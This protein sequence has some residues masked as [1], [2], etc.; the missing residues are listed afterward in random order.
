MK[1]K[2]NSKAAAPTP[3]KNSKKQLEPETEDDEESSEDKAEEEEKMVQLPVEKAD[4]AKFKKD[5]H[6]KVW[7]FNFWKKV[8]L[9]SYLNFKIRRPLPCVQMSSVCT[10]VV[11]L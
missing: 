7:N 8:V 3:T 1:S 5:P 9:F 11:L 6:F 2:A 4:K 10:P